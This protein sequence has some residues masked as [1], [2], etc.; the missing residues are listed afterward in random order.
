M[1]DRFSAEAR[2]W[3]LAT[4][5]RFQQWTWRLHV[6]GREVIDGLY[7]RKE[8]FI[9][10]FWHGKYVPIL[11]LF[12]GYHANVFTSVSKRGDVIA[13]IC[14]SFGYRCTQIPDHGGEKSLRKMEDALSDSIAAG[15][16]VDGPLGPFHVVKP[17]VI[18]LASKL[19]FYLLPVS[20]DSRRKTALKNR[21]DQM[22]LPHLFTTVC[23]VIGEPVRVPATLDDAD[24]SRWSSRL[25]QAMES[26]D[27]RAAS[28]VRGRD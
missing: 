8:R 19:G 28:L 3:T 4:A 24:T 5:L 12:E 23:L 20:V 6:E 22:E 11:P 15:I 26:L 1:L 13:R 2:G 17:G 25:A 14:R 7:E 10:C 9:L 27:A 16:A 21:W 18:R